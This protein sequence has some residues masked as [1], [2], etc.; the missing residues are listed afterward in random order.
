MG[1]QIFFNGGFHEETEKLL[2]IQDRG[3]CFADGLFEVIRCVNGRFLLFTKHIARMRQSAAELRMDFP[4]SDGELL[5]AC[6]E[7]SRRNGVLDGE[8]YLEITRGEAPRYHTFPEGVRPTF[9]IVLIP[10][11]K[12]PE[13]CWSVGVRTV[14]FPDTRGAYCHLKTINL[15]PNVLGKQHAKEKGAFEALFTR[16]DARGRYLTEGP[17]S[18]IFCIRN[19]VLFTPEL[20]NILPGTTRHFVIQLAREEGLEVREQRLHLQDFLEADEHFISS[21]VSEV[22]P[23]IQ[24]DETVLGRGAK[25][26]LTTR[27]QERYAAFKG[28]HLE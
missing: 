11:R 18:S 6:R 25:G 12:M 9:F 27:L 4:H 3:L 2:S 15:L 16:E 5:E 21:T 24:L 22:M 8:L 23:V 14:T 17:S 10:L 13:N 1:R 28:D 20:D 19:G 26:P 7:L